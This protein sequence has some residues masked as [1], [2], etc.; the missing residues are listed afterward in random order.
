MYRFFA[1]AFWTAAA[2]AFLVEAWLWD[3]L[4]A[5]MAR[6]VALLPLQPLRRALQSILIRTPPTFAF[7]LFAIPVLAILPFKFLGLALLANGRVA[8]GVCVFFLAK[9]IGLGVTAFVY[10]ICQERLMLLGWF[11]RSRDWLL[12]LRAW[13]HRQMQPYVRALRGLRKRLLAGS[14][15]RAP[16]VL[17]RLL[18]LR[19]RARGL[20]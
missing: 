17:R 10:Q 8:S 3:F 13:A 18:L 19:A 7:V 6:I 16:P 9:T 20:A 4:G 2:A 12:A 14:A 11:V 15:L 5:A 1:R